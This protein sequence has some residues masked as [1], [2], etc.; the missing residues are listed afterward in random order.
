MC[1]I[2]IKKGAKLSFYN[3]INLADEYQLLERKART[4]RY[5]SFSANQKIDEKIIRYY[6]DQGNQMYLQRTKV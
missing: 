2:S 1:N 3:G 5:I 6:L 4:T